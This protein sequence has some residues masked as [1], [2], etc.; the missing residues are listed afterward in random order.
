M[1]FAA[2]AEEIQVRLQLIMNWLLNFERKNMRS[3]LEKS[4][5]NLFLNSDIW[6]I[7]QLFFLFLLLLILQQICNLK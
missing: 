7:R 1:R 4:L 3:I 5:I 6:T 2:I